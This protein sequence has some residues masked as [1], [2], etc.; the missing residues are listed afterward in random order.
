MP[1]TFWTFMVGT[2]ALAGVWPLSGFFSKD[3][4]L[5]AC[6]STS[7]PLLFILG[8]A[9]AA[10]TTFY[11]FRLVFVAFFGERRTGVAPVS[12]F[13]K[14]AQAGNERRQARRL[15]TP[16]ESPGVVMVWP[17][18]ILA[19]ASIVGGVIGIEALFGGM[20]KRRTRTSAR[21]AGP[22]DLPI[23]TCTRWPP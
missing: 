21:L 20:F 15:S 18:R 16:H 14:T 12:D 11:M 1:V 4:I 17:L 23:S 9:V 19:V 5:A 7:L 3:A 22:T 10:L 8:V 13:N 6:A 2:L